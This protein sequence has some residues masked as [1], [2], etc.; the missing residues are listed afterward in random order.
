MSFV[1]LPASLTRMMQQ[2]QV[3]FVDTFRALRGVTP[4]EI[5]LLLKSITAKR[6]PKRVPSVNSDFYDILA[7]L[8][9]EERAIQQKIR[10]YMEEKIRP[11]A[12][13]FW[14]RGEFPHEIV[15]GFARL[16]AETL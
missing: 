16:I 1:T 14:E 3:P 8:S 10:S 2:V 5:G 15:P 12:N 4:Q 11:I 6:R 13:S 9:P 7:E